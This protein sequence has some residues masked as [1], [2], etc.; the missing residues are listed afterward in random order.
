MVW[1]SPKG[2]PKPA[3]L[4]LGRTDLENARL[5]HQA[6]LE[7]QGHGDN[8]RCAVFGVL[9]TSFPGPLGPPRGACLGV[10]SAVA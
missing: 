4:P 1:A 7:R 3:T 2:W 10:R 5:V 6:C 9:A 8:G